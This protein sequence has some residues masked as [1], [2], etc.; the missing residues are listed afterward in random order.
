VWDAVV[1]GARCAGATTALLLARQGHRVLLLDRAK[2][3]SD[4][5]STLFIHQ[6]GIARLKRWGLLDA[7]I[8]S[9]CPRIDNVTYMLQDVALRAALPAFGDI[10]FAC[11]PRRHILDQILITAAVDAGADLAEE[12]LLSELV[13][14]GDGRVSGVR[15][16]TS[17]GA[18]A[19]EESRLV[20]GADGM[21]S[22]TAQLTGS[23]L[24]IDDPLTTC[25][26]YSGWA[27]LEI[28]FEMRERP[29]RWLATVPTNDGITLIL[30]YFPQQEFA[31][32]KND[33]YTR[34]LA[35]IQESAPDVFD[36]LATSEQVVRLHGTGDQQN[37]FRQAA[38][39]GWA[40]VGDAGHHEDSITARGITNA[41]LQSEILCEEIGGQLDSESQLTAALSRFSDR[42]DAALIDTYRATIETAQLHVQRS[43]LEMLR[44]ISEKPA[45]TQRYFA[46]AAGIISMDEF[47]TPELVAALY[48]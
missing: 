1:V 18:L 26:Y 40:L 3:P 42:R 9:G 39:P 29:G 15:F 38:G 5:M 45:L 19:T 8:S 27:G 48:R 30:T 36:Q 7:V 43:R 35:A 21:R 28:G 11:A 22:K 37:F 16:R 34:H 14:D 10:N 23:Q 44:K 46:L 4:T 33:P 25:I 31:A 20:I 12:C 17:A 13:S 6:P 41:F 47:L 2:F 24:T 32:V